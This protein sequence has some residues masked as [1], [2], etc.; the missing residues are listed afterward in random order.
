MSEVKKVATRESYGNALKEL[1]A[2]NPNVLV[3]DADLAGATKT[4][5][6]KKAYPDRF[7]DCGIAEGNMVGIAAG[8]ATTG[9]IPFCSSFAMFAAGR[10]FE[11]VRNSVGYPHLNVKIAAT[12][13][14]ISVGEDG[15]TH[16][17]N[18]D[19]AL[20][21][22]IPGMVVIN[23]ADDVEARAAVKAAAEY[24]GP[25]YLRFGRLAVP[26]FNDE[27]NYKFEI[28]KGILLREGTDL[29][30]VATGLCVNSALE[31]AEKLAA[32]G[33]SAEVINIHTIKPLDEEI[34]LKSAKKTGKVVTAEEHSVIGGLGSAVCDV[35]SE[36]LPTPV[37]KIGVYDVFGESGPAVKL[38]EKYKLDGAGVYEQIKDWLK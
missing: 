23:P 12:H 19:I 9:K 16:Q 32:E 13:A 1:G 22:T 11:Q 5:V 24:E 25:V 36:K 38:L 26:V 17:C 21:R 18:E 8:L 6:F 4:G 2:E 7:F 10:A 30:I 27:A 3:L 15:A 34:I 28:G 33:I 31:A 20:M 37:K 14:G 35:L 29:T